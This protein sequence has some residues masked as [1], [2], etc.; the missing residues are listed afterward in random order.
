MKYL[1][2]PLLISLVYVS[3][4]PC[5]KYQCK[6]YSQQFQGDTCIFYDKDTITNWLLPCS[7]DKY[8][9]VMLSSNSTCT[10][11]PETAEFYPGEKCTSDEECHSNSCIAN[12]CKG[13][14]EKESCSSIYDCDPSLMCLYGV[15]S[16]GTHPGSS[17]N[18]RGECRYGYE[19]KYGATSSSVCAP[20]FSRPAGTP[21]ISCEADFL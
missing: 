17:C 18:R 12:T 15:C 11:Y 7:H 3:S 4:N 16:A 13:A 14:G 2:S 19:C 5:F 10:S 1:T 6:N 21:I 9:D 8:C 20:Y